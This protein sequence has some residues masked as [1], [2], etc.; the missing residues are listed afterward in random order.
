MYVLSDVQ[1]KIKKNKP[2]RMFSNQYKPPQLM[3][4]GHFPH[5][6]RNGARLTKHDITVIT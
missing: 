3:H 1:T 5:M 6:T 4:Y 2:N